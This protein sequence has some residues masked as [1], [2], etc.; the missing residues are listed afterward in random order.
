[1][2]VWGAVFWGTISTEK[3]MLPHH[4]GVKARGMQ[5]VRAS[6][7]PVVTTRTHLGLD[8]LISLQ[9]TGMRQAAR[10]VAVGGP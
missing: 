1:V 8:V 3:A 6:D 2:E 7:H 10:R 4:R 5:R 9:R